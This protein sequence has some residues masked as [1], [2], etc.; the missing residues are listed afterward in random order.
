MK[1]KSTHQTTKNTMKKKPYILAAIGDAFGKFGKAIGVKVNSLQS[2]PEIINPEDLGKT[3]KLDTV[4]NVGVLLEFR[5]N[6]ANTIFDGFEFDLDRLIQ[7]IEINE[8]FKSVLIQ[9]RESLRNQINIL[10]NEGLIG[11]ES[12]RTLIINYLV[13]FN[14]PKDLHEALPNQSLGFM[15]CLNS[16]DTLDPMIGGMAYHEI[17]L[18]AERVLPITE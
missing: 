6:N 1:R 17:E 5:S 14:T 4:K 11:T 13:T 8:Q 9:R 16:N 2:T 15:I 10:I 3:E 18:L 7:T 12:F